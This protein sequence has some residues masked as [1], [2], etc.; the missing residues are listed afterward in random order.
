MSQPAD[1][2][3]GDTILIEHLPYDLDAGLAQRAAIGLVVLAT[4]YTIEHEW[5]SMF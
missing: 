2:A 5:L 4:D 1:K 3:I